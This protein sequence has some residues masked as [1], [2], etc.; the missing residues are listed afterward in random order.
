MESWSSK[1]P[2]ISMEFLEW[3]RRSFQTPKTPWSGAPIH[4]VS[5]LDLGTHPL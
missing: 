5:A 1:T 2:W 3:K 4:P